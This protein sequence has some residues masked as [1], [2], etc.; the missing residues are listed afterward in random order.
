MTADINEQKETNE[1]TELNAVEKLKKELA[2]DV[3]HH[4][5][6]Q[7]KYQTLVSP[8]GVK[9]KDKILAQML[10]SNIISGKLSA[11]SGV[12]T[13]DKFKN[14]KPHTVIKLLYDGTKPK[15]VLKNVKGKIRKLLNHLILKLNITKEDDIT[16]LSILSNDV[17]QIAKQFKFRESDHLKIIRYPDQELGNRSPWINLKIDENSVF[18]NL[19]GKNISPE[20]VIN[21]SLTCDVIIGPCHIIDGSILVMYLDTCYFESERNTVF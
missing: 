18:K 21:K 1:Q 2:Q 17:I 4:L 13:T 5:V 3:E 12:E 16:G 7:N 15:I 6:W 19:N 9:I 14:I 20:D 11:P 10:A 8:N